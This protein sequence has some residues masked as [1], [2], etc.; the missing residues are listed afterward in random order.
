M[1]RAGPRGARRYASPSVFEVASI[2]EEEN[3]IMTPAV[4]Q[5]DTIVP[6]E[7]PP[8]EPDTSPLTLEISTGAG[9][10]AVGGRGI[11]GGLFVTSGAT[12]TL[13]NSHVIGNFASSS[14]DDI[15]GTV[16]YL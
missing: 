2:A 8:R 16:T 15:D 1:L 3:I 12:A 13:K 9:N 7:R 14:N 5:S 4:A 10:A 11:G 6:P